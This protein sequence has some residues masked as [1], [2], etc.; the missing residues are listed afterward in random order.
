MTQQRVSLVLH[1]DL[2]LADKRTMR[3]A[4][5]DRHYTASTNSTIATNAVTAAAA[6]A[7]GMTLS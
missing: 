5:N 4:R 2:Q 6:A 7:A 1:D 3:V